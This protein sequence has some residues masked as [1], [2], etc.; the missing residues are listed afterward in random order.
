VLTPAIGAWRIGR[1]MPN[2]SRMRRSCQLFI[3]DLP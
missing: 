2:K 1:S 3:I